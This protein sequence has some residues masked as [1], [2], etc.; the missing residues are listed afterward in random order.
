MT[1]ALK[2]IIRFL[3]EDVQVNR[4]VAYHAKENPASGKVMKNVYDIL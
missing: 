1:E 2:E 3:F 4:I